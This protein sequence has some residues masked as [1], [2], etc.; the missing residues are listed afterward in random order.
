MLLVKYYSSFKH[1]YFVFLQLYDWKA[2]TQVGHSQVHCSPS[3]CIASLFCLLTKL[4]SH[5][6]LFSYTLTYNICCSFPNIERAFP[7]SWRVQMHSE[8][9]NIL[10]HYWLVNI[11]GR[12]CRP[13]Q[14]FNGSSASSILKFFF[15]YLIL[16][17][18]PLPRDALT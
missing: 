6:F 2:T 18:P 12:Q 4:S 7:I 15:L 17:F 16:P 14:V 8:Q 3:H 11:P 13:L 5:A 1:I 9:N 10:L